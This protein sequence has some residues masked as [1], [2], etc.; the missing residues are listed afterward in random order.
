MVGDW[1]VLKRWLRKQY[2]EGAVISFH[3]RMDN[4]NLEATVTTGTGEDCE[5]IDEWQIERRG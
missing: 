4:R 5:V 2:P 3:V 1:Y